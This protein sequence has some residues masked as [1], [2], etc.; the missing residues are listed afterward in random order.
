MCNS[1][2]LLSHQWISYMQFLA[3]DE[4]RLLQKKLDR[5]IADKPR[6]KLVLYCESGNRDY[7]KAAN[8]ITASIRKFS[9]VN[10][11][12]L[13]CITG[14]GWS[15][16][17]ATDERWRRYRLWRA[18]NGDER[19]LYDAPGHRFERGEGDSLSQVIE[20][21]LQLGWDALLAATPRRQLLFLSHD[22]RMEIYR[23]FE[24]RQLA[25]RL[26]ALGYW[27]RATHQG[28]T[29]GSILT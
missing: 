11:L 16:G 19:R 5:Q 6:P 12:F 18:A 1:I 8:T 17:N 14:D 7:S 3:R 9:E 2:L 4:A 29:R 25:E 20:F 24:R 21:A 27:R 28:R 22:D 10:L 13:F 15:E 26:I 23:G